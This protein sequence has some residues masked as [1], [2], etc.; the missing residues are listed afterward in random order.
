MWPCYPGASYKGRGPSNFPGRN[1]NYGPAGKDLGL[2]LLRN[3]GIVANDSLVAFETALWFWMTPSKPKPSCHQV[4]VGKYRPNRSDLAENR[5]SGF[6]LVTNIVN[7]GLE[8]GIP[9][10]P[11]VNDRIGFFRRYAKL[12]GVDTGPNLDCAHQKP[13]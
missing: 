2:D 10:D 6:G 12:L 9:D 13:Y 8:C 3:P 11:R 4:M 5:T 7:G 1:F